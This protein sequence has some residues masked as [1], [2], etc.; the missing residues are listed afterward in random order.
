MA[1]ALALEAGQRNGIDA[2]NF[3]AMSLESNQVLSCLAYLLA[4]EGEAMDFCVAWVL[5]CRLIR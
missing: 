1:L 5:S 2:W 4:V 3:E